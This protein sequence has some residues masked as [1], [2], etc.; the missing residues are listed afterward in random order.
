MKKNSLL[1]VVGLWFM[2]HSFAAET[3][4]MITSKNYVASNTTKKDIFCDLHGVLLVKNFRTLMCGGVGNLLSTKETVYGKLSLLIQFILVA[5]DYRFYKQMYA[6]THLKDQEGR[7]LGKDKITESYF[8]SIK[9]LGY[10]DVYDALVSFA[11]NIFVPNEKLIADLKTLKAQGHR[12]H[13]FSNIGSAT[14]KDAHTKFP[15]LFR[16]FDDAQNRINHD[17]EEGEIY[18]IWKPQ[19]AAF[20]AVLETTGATPENSIMI[21]DKLVNLPTAQGTQAAAAKAAKKGYY[22]ETA[23]PLWMNGR[24]GVQ[25]SKK[26]HE[27]AIEQLKELCK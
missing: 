24:G 25:Y 5:G 17:I 13:I 22:L 3:D 11:N 1:L 2:A 15:E 16:I 9:D 10:H 12:L 23:D 4:T 27:T 14:L 8:N 19:K 21:D 7:S 18:T 20:D 26:N 6:L